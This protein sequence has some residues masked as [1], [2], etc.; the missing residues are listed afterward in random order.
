MFK[1]TL[2]I[3]YRVKKKNEL[4]FFLYKGTSLVVQ[5][6]MVQRGA[7]H[8]QRKISGE[9]QQCSFAKLQYLRLLR[10]RKE[11]KG[12]VCTGIMLV[13]TANTIKRFC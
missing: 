3:D 8:G 7:K 11:N 1:Y 4:I 10:F 12:K 5:W 9:I 6:R 13:L 2:Q